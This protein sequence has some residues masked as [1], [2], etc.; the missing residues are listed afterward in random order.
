MQTAET[1]D[2]FLEVFDKMDVIEKH[3]F[4]SGMKRHLAQPEPRGQEILEETMKRIER[5]RSGDHSVE[6]D[7]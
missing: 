5:Y 3:I 2:E 7:L 6:I 1:Y 4:L